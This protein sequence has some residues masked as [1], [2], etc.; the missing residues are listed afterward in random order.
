MSLESEVVVVKVS[1]EDE[2]KQKDEKDRKR[3][4]ERERRHRQRDERERERD[5]EREKNRDRRRDDSDTD[6]RNEN[7][8]EKAPKKK[9]ISPEEENLL[10]RTGGAYIP[11]A[12]LRLLQAKI[13][14][15]SSAAFQR[16]AWEAL[17]KSL[18]GLINKVNISNISVIIRELFRENVVRGRGLL[19]RSILQA[20]ALSP[21]FTHVY[22]SL[23]SVINSKFPQIGELI[24]RRLIIQ[25]RQGYRRNDKQLCLSSTRFIAHLVNQQVAHELLA[26]EILTLLLETPTDDAVEVAI[27]FLKESGMKLTEVSPRGINAVFERLRSILHE[28]HLDKRVQYMIE[29]MF[30]IRKD[31]FLDHQIVIKDLDLIEEAEQYTHLIKLDDEMD[32][33]NIL[34]VF[35]FDPEFEDTEEKYKSIRKDIL[36][37]GSDDESGEEQESGEE[38]E[39]E[40]EEEEGDD[41]DKVII[42][43]TET[44]LVALRRTIYLTIQSSLDFEECA[45]KLLKMELKP[46]QEVELCHMI[47]DCCAQ[48]RTYEKF[49]GLLGQRFCQL[50]KIYVTPFEQ[51]F[52][53]SLLMHIR[54]NEDDTT[55]S[56]RIF[57]KILFQELSEYMGLPRLNERLKDASLQEAFDGLFPRDNP[58]NSRF[59]INFFTSI[60][61][62]GLTDELREHLKT[63]SK[64]PVPVVSPT[65]I[66]VPSESSSSEAESESSDSSSQSSDS[67]PDVPVSKKHKSKHSKHSKSAKKPERKKAEK[68][69]PEKSKSKSKS[70][71]KEKKRKERDVSLSSPKRRKERDVSLSSPKRRKERD[72]SL[73]SPKRRKERDVSLSSPKRRKE[74]DVSPSSPKR[75]K[76]R[77]VSP[78]SP[79]RRKE[80][81]VSPSSPKR[82]RRR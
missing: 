1:A 65:E 64:P 48:Q 46:G 81:D 44:N 51:I 71:N 38:E 7:K 3:R 27:G 82:R 4:E 56:S 74:R 16:I 57:I 70:K 39:E 50:N 73:S 79:K 55:S 25:F 9:K 75:R 61:L 58:R 34:N 18:N 76:E 24:L 17:K 45:H 42:D 12:K 28:G 31:K 35:K 52:V 21:T 62:G 11:P 72:V 78:S 29:V 49:F 14:D 59:A 54:L 13:T 32:G 20:Q 6:K 60:G 23:V 15:K 43:N 53:D 41:K 66:Q 67:E 80:R 36:E 30:A 8:D 2:A 47:L 37:E 10:T 33:E 19:S 63:Q 26:L 69:K 22:A 77:D 68:S 40:E 5:R